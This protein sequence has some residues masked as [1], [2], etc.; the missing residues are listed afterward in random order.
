MSRAM[1][2]A[3]GLAA[4]DLV[5]CSALLGVQHRQAGIQCAAFNEWLMEQIKILPSELRVIVLDPRAAYPFGSEQNPDPKNSRPMVYFNQPAEAV[6]G[7]FLGTY[8]RRLVASVCRITN[9][10]PG[11]LFRPFSEM[12]VHVPRALHASCCTAK[13]QPLTS[14][15]DY[16]HRRQFMGKAQ[17]KSEAP[18]GAR[19][20][21]PF[22]R[23]ALKIYAMA[24]M[25]V[26]ALLR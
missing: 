4:A 25:K 24:P 23:C 12:P 14:L 22:H 18:W 10:A 8:R 11:Y 26:G 6:T 19:I 1:V 5:R 15:L 2:P 21:D 16:H 17:D 3:I 20:L 13:I 7:T 9:A